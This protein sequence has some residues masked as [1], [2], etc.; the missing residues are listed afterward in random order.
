L[1]RV[2]EGYQPTLLVDEAD[3]FLPDNDELRGVLNSGHRKGG[4]VLRTVG[5]DHEPR[6]FNTFC[7]TAI[8]LIGKLPDTLHDRSVVVDLKRKLRTETVKPF[9]PDRA[10][11]LDVLARKAVRWA[12][13]NASGMA[14][15]DP[16]MPSEIINREADNWRPLLAIAD[17]A[18]GDDWPKRARAALEAAHVAGADD[19]ASRL[20]LLLG[21]IRA[22]FKTDKA[23]T[24]PDMFGA[25]QTVIRSSALVKILVALDGRPWAEMGRDHKALTQNRLA[26]MLKP[27]GIGPGKIGRRA[28][29]VNGYVQNHFKDVFERYL[30][31]EVPPEVDTQTQP[32]QMGTSDISKVDTVDDGCPV[33]N[34]QET[35][36]RRACVRVSGSEG[37]LEGETLV[38]TRFEPQERTAWGVTF[39]L[40]GEALPG[41]A[42][43]YCKDATPDDVGPVMV[44]KAA[45][46]L[47]EACAPAWISDQNRS[48]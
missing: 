2:V 21:D 6:M 36:Q 27:V 48:R 1:F 34:M 40:L 3:T 12:Q 37:G 5:D 7:P 18:G 26:K 17:A 20:E 10:D 41:A 28:A 15:R 29:R 31:L 44:V 32:R 46:P 35:Q 30:P 11:Y 4:T 23:V 25:D 39:T 13:D 9:R 38:G 16:Q 19:D 22:A 8:A 45:G 47:H 14:D 33:A 24:L 43:L 42:C